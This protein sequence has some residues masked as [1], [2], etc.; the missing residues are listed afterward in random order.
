[1]K[2][3]VL[4]PNAT[5]ATVIQRIIT[6]FLYLRD[7]HDVY[8]FH[9][10][11]NG[12]YFNDGKIKQ[13][14]ENFVPTSK[15]EQ[16]DKENTQTLE[17]IISILKLNQTSAVG[18][19]FE[20]NFLNRND[21]EGSKHSF[22]KF[23]N[24][25]FDVIVSAKRRNTFEQALSHS[26]KQ[27]EGLGPAYDR[28]ARK[29]YYT[30][31]TIHEGYFRSSLEGYARFCEFTKQHF[32]KCYD[33]YYEDFVD[34]PD[35]VLKKIFNLSDN[36]ENTIRNLLQCDF[37][38]LT[39]YEYHVSRGNIVPD[40]DMAKKLL[41]YKNFL[42]TL[43]KNSILPT[44]GG[45]PPAVNSDPVKTHSLSDKVIQFKNIKTCYNT[46]LEF[47]KDRPCM[48]SSY[49]LYDHWNNTYITI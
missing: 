15:Q 29:K 26:Y 49:A 24:E 33:I 6:I 43:H 5:G 19:M 10:L 40:T 25:Y 13:G 42:N 34:D 23:L 11:L 14:F 7:Y 44:V 32:P 18:R 46:Y 22:F 31:N 4:T 2:V 48:N 28:D 12:V 3:L 27:I 30:Y 16:L 35:A 9:E 20:G 17:E 37:K 36:T 41:K 39:H 1:M 21:S 47:S 8:N 38:S 45:W